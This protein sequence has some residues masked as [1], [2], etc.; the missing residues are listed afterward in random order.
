MGSHCGPRWISSEPCTYSHTVRVR[1]INQN[2]P[3]NTYGSP[4]RDFAF[5]TFIIRRTKLLDIHA[6]LLS[7]A[8]RSGT[9]VT[10]LLRLPR[11]DI[12]G[13]NKMDLAASSS[14]NRWVI[15]DGCSP[16]QLYVTINIQHIN[17]EKNTWRCHR[18][19]FVWNYFPHNLLA[20]KKFVAT[21]CKGRH[22]E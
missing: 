20:W 6:L 12:M 15:R 4:L 18:F 16:K 9:C 2:D 8:K 10:T 19:L 22:Y 21:R 5:A 3:M 1:W 17:V 11:V 13:N 7:V 14:L